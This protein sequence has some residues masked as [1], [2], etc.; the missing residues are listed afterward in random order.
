MRGPVAAVDA[1][2]GADAPGS[3]VGAAGA[4]GAVGAGSATELG[5]VRHQLATFR[6]QSASTRWYS[7][8]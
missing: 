7:N 5:V 3:G 1:E 6:A 2:V 8:T 4:V